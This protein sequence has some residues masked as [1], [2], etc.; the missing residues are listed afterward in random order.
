MRAYL[1]DVMHDFSGIETHSSLEVEMSSF[2]NRSSRAGKCTASDTHGMTPL[3]IFSINQRFK[4]YPTLITPLLISVL[5]NASRSPTVTTP[6][7]VFSNN[8]RFTKHPTVTTPLLIFSINASSTVKRLFSFSVS[9]N[10][11][12][13]P[14]VTTPLLIFSNNQRSKKHPTVTTRLLIF[15]Y[16]RFKTSTVKCL[17]SFSVSINASKHRR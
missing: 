12:R 14:T 2:E 9:I 1:Y 7:L 6:R 17:F 8:Q 16:Q 3:F 5:I 10:A 4:K 15:Q 11:S 13:Y